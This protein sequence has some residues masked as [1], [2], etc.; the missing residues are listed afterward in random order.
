[1]NPEKYTQK[2]Q[3][4]LSN[5]QT[6][7]LGSGHQ[8]LLPEH[9]LKSI[10]EDSDQLAQKLI[11][12]CDGNLDILNAELTNILQKIPKVEGSGAGS[13]TMSQDLARILIF[14]EKL[15]QKNSDQFVTSEALLQAILEDNDNQ[16]AKAL[17]LAGVTIIALRNAINKIRGGK[18][19]TSQSAETTYQALEKYA[20]DLTKKAREGKIDPVIGRD[21]EIRRTMQVLSRRT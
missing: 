10:L 11:Q 5:A 6:L 4:I 16:G 17:K 8:K 13:L 18:N 3:N 2:A 9:L 15:I 12:L 20:Q 14:V 7:A 21:E 19:V 1:M